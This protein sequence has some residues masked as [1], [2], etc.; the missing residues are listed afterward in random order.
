[1]CGAQSR[2]QKWWPCSPGDAVSPHPRA[3][4]HMA[5]VVWKGTKGAAKGVGKAGSLG[6]AGA[7]KAAMGYLEA[8]D[9]YDV[10]TRPPRTR[11]CAKL[12]SRR[13]ST[14]IPT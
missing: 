5:E 7:E 3:P 4:A 2:W 1:M 13:C 8:K 14:P 10:S 9:K 12:A 11:V 6:M